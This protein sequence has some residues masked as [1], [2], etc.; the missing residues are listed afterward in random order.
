ME[1]LLLGNGFDLNYHLPTK[2]NNFLHTVEYLTNINLISPKTAGE[3]FSDARLTEKDPFIAKCYDVNKGAF[4]A[5]T[6]NNEQILKLTKLA[7]DN[8]WFKYLLSSYNT[9]VGWIDFEREIKNVLFQ[10]KT[11]LEIKKP[12]PYFSLMN[13]QVLVHMLKSFPV[14][15]K[16]DEGSAIYSLK[17]E[18]LLEEP[19]GSKNFKV[20]VDKIVETLFEDLRNLAEMLKIYLSEFVEKA[21]CN[22]PNNDLNEWVKGYS[23]K[24][25]I[26]FNYTDT[27]EKLFSNE[28][29]IHI[30][31]TNDAQIVLGINPDNDDEETSVDT[32]FLQ[33]KK[34]Y[35]R[36]FYQTDSSYLATLESLEQDVEEKEEIFLTV[37]GHSLDETDKDIIK[38]LFRRATYINVLYYNSFDLSKHMKNLVS[39]YGKR[40]FDE[41]RYKKELTFTQLSIEIENV[42]NFD[43]VLGKV[44]AKAIEG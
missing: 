43:G 29:V 33:F 18:Y 3:V 38:E 26:S 11:V 17:R 8:M 20:N 41:L 39:I 1:I 15:A 23:P 40:G 13:N 42:K 31:G 30:H 16:N 22:I 25:I 10:F 6:L 4:D 5:V 14:F 9:D 34:Y 32:T 2:Y 44:V 37:I 28:S 7:N 21:V 27:Y 36:V 19:F 24:Y 35:Q 12:C